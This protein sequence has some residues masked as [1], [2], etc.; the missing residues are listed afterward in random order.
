MNCSVG[1][2]NLRTTRSVN[3]IV[4]F[5][6][7]VTHYQPIMEN[8]AVCVPGSMFVREYCMYFPLWARH[9][10]RVKWFPY[11]SPVSSQQSPTRTHTRLH[12]RAMFRI[13]FIS[14]P[15][16]E[17]NGWHAFEACF[18]RA[19][20]PY[21]CSLELSL[22]VESWPTA[23]GNEFWIYLDAHTHTSPLLSV[24][25]VSHHVSLTFMQPAFILDGTL[26]G[27]R[28]KVI[29]EGVLS[30]YVS[31]ISM[32]RSPEATAQALL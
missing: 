12:G 23:E 28:I 2:Q 17:Q 29:A 10:H 21:K 18:C 19:C 14:V 4:F 22:Y 11:S 3:K 9:S 16:P 7:P 27:R 30:L 26:L 32:Q 24:T 1:L 20:G 8:N 5:P 13:F 6:L 31:S 15:T 25:R